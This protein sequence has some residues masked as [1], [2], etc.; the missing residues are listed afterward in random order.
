MVDRDA[1]PFEPRRKHGKYIDTRHGRRRLAVIADSSAES[2]QAF[3]KAN[4]KPGSTLPAEGYSSYPGLGAYRHD[5]EWSAPW[6][7]TPSFRG[8]P[9]TTA[10]IK[11]AFR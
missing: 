6:P 10:S 5:P 1:N 4:V 7:V 3:V 2:I 9:R 8:R 11:S